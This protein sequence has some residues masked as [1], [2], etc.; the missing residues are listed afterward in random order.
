A[1]R[2][3]GAGFRA[4][5]LT[6]LVGFVGVG[7]GL[8]RIRRVPLLAFGWKVLIPASLA[9]ILMIATIRVWRQHGGSTPVYIV[10]GAILGAL[11]LLA[12]A[13]DA[14]AEKRRAAARPAAGSA[15][16][17]S[18]AAAATPRAV[19]AEA[20][21]GTGR[22]GGLPRPP[23][24]SAALPRHRGDRQRRRHAG[25]TRCRSARHRQGGD[26]CLIS[27][28]P[29]RGLASRSGRC[30]GR[31]TRSSTPRRSGPPRPGSTAVT[32]STA[33]RTAWRNAS[34]ANCA[35]GPARPTP[36]T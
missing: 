9:W 14:A 23:H 28:I 35:P 13:G 1:G 34:A 5:L 26:R 27:W 32:S 3:R 18:G 36:S 6:R 25:R 7:G 17:G 11:L 19:V 24:G 12:W 30:S 29:S 4:W 10:G 31:S 15:A 2:W 20:R 22:I 21:A 16:A 33:G 8:P